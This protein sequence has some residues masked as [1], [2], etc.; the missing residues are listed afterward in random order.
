MTAQRPQNYRVK[1]ILISSYQNVEPP[2]DLRRKA[3]EEQ[4]FR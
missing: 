3:E 2:Y 4:H 1:C